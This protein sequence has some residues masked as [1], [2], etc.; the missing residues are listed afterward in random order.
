M[1][2]PEGSL[3]VASWDDFGMRHAP[4]KV[5]RDRLGKAGSLEI[6]LYPHLE[7]P[8][9]V[10]LKLD[11]A[12][13]RLIGPRETEYVL[14]EPNSKERESCER[15]LARAEEVRR[16]EAAKPKRAVPE[17]FKRA[18]AARKGTGAAHKAIEAMRQ[19]LGAT[20]AQII[21]LT[22]WQEPTV[23]G[24][25]STMRSKGTKIMSGQDKAGNLTYRIIE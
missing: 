11:A 19:G 24:F 15:V 10:A 8:R 16:A 23:R 21:A 12:T 13:H 3:Y 20:K 18:T 7:P 1:I 4:A 6:A 25:V 2:Y 5:L 14:A 22:G 17:A 9:E